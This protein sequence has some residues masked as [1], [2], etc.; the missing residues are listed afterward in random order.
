MANANSHPTTLP[1]G[2][3]PTE[4]TGKATKEEISEY[5]CLIGLLLYLIIG[6]R[7]DISFVVPNL[8]RFVANPSSDHT[9]RAK[10]I[11]HYLVGT[12]NY[13]LKYSH[14]GTGLG[15]FTDSD[16]AADKIQHQSVTGFFFEMAG[17]CIS[18]RSHALHCHLPKLSIWHYPIA[19]ARQS[20]LKPS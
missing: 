3:S 14:K 16:W 5:Q 20:G 17:G 2:W 11:L 4:N 13:M 7:P 18:W 8:S 15:A 6:T 9:E 12:Q 1:T 10:Y 19:P